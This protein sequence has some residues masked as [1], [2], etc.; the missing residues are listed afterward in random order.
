MVSK[1]MHFTTELNQTIFNILGTFMYARRRSQWPRGLR[2]EM[3]LFARSKTGTVG[4]NPTQGMD[5]CV[6][7]LCLCCS[8]CR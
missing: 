1:N 5:V 6:F 7:I 3:S 2:H 8:V 4:S